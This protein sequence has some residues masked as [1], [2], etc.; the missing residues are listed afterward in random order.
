MKRH[1]MRNSRLHIGRLIVVCVIAAPASAFAEAV[2]R[3]TEHGFRVTFPQTW[4]RTKAKAPGTAV[5]YGRM[6]TRSEQHPL[7]TSCNVTVSVAQSAKGKKQVQLNREIEEQAPH[8]R[9]QLGSQFGSISEV[10]TRSIDSATALVLI[11]SSTENVYGTQIP[12]M[13]QVHLF[14]RPA[15]SFGLFCQATA[16]DFQKARLLFDLIADSFRFE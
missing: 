1:A 14:F 9:A 7:I 16:S 15:R 2:Y 11:T 6:T 4:Q 12:M 5:S 3:D 10:Y 8:A 13:R